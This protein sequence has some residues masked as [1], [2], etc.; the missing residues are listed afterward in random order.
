MTESRD[1]EISWRDGGVPASGR[2]GDIYYSAEDGLAESRYVF[3]QGVGAPGIWAG[4]PRFTIGELGFGAGLNFAAT[5][6]LWRKTAGQGARLHYVA[7]EGFPM[8]SGDLS[9]ALQGFPEVARAASPLIEGWPSRRQGFHLLRF[10]G[11]VT[12][13]VIFEPVE[14]ALEDLS[15]RIDAWF[16]DGF[17]PAKNPEMWSPRVM[18]LLAARSAKGARAA[19]F[20]AAGAVRRAL[21]DAGFAVTRRPG[22]GA[23]RDSIHAVFEGRGDPIDPIDEAAWFHGPAPLSSNPHVA[24]IGAG[25]AGASAAAALASEGAAVTVHDALGAIATGASGAPSGVVQP[26]PL[27]DGSPAAQF[28]AAA[29]GYAAAVYDRNDPLC[30]RRGV[31]VL[32]RDGGDLERYKRL[33]FGQALSA[34]EVND[35]AG[36]AVNVPGVLFGDGGVLDAASACRGLLRDIPTVLGARIES[37]ARTG[38]GWRLRDTAGRVYEADA[39][40]LAGGMDTLLLSGDAGLGLHANR[41][42]VSLH[43]AAPG[44]R[45]LKCVLTFGGY[46]TPPVPGPGGEP[47]Q[48]LGG[49]FARI[50]DWRGDDRRA[51]RTEDHARNMAKLWGRL[52]DMAA[53]LG[54]LA[55][56]WTGLRATTPDR[57]PLAGP[58]PDTE[59]FK[60]AAPP[61]RRGGALTG[62]PAAACQP[63]LFVLSGLGSRGFLTAP[64][65]GEILASR[66][67]GTPLPVPASVAPLLHPARFLVRA[68]KKGLA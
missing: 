3:L 17:A 66:I 55:G 26:R 38:G 50:D 53:S 62:A 45:G 46:L 41:G 27:A 47:I 68:M 18:E 34:D 5:C 7:V 12:L 35:A 63:G 48:V 22:F 40:V 65:C 13:L 16:L 9:Q 23:K 15:A 8:S 14:R 31:L 28:F 33:P 32:G 51:A 11:G 67:C 39:V 58:A 10:Q 43:R 19:T 36:A 57:L 64:L 56:G 20:T 24:V 30:L 29:Y 49:T 60:A 61:H 21:V 2:F 59:A 42:Q 52:P 4:R 37:L 6:D 54:P 44:L 25:V 1:P